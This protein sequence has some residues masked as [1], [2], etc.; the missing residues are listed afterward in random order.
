MFIDREFRED[1]SS[2]IRIVAKDTSSSQ[3]AKFDT[4]LIWVVFVWSLTHSFRLSNISVF[5][6]L[7][8][9][10]S[11]KTKLILFLRNKNSFIHSEP[12]WHLQVFH[13]SWINIYVW[14]AASAAIKS[15]VL[16]SWP[17]C[18]VFQIHSCSILF[19]PALNTNPISM[20]TWSSELGPRENLKQYR[21]RNAKI[22]LKPIQ[23]RTRIYRVDQERMDEA[24]TNREWEG[25]WKGSVVPAR[26]SHGQVF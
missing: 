12:S 20:R 9:Q 21:I 25:D 22:G 17:V 18:D 10:L 19:N 6:K 3:N 11:R 4:E 2:L 15:W 16:N 8:A 5:Q 1:C 23:K 14:S 13:L 24:V 7:F 26:C